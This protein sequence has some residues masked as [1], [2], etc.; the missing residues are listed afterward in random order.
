[1]TRRVPVS[2]YRMGLQLLKQMLRIRQALEWVTGNFTKIFLGYAAVA[3]IAALVY[4][5]IRVF[6][7]F[8]LM[9]IQP[10]AFYW[11]WRL[12]CRTH[13]RLRRYLYPEEFPSD[14]YERRTR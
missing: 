2:D 5:D 1:M 12:R 8:M 9:T 4:R 7:L 3:A 11:L 14:D 13:D 10:I 6:L